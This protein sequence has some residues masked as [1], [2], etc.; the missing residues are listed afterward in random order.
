MTVPLIVL[1]VASLFTTSASAF[2]TDRYRELVGMTVVM[3]DGGT[4]DLDTLTQYQEELIAIGVR[5]AREYAAATPDDAALMNFVADSADA[6]KGMSL[7][8][9]EAAWH[10][11][12][13]L[14]EI[15]IDFH[16]LDHF[17][18]AVSHMDTV[19]HPA[20]AYIALREYRAHPNPD[21]LDQIRDELSEVLAHVS[22]L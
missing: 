11:G 10:E 6:M 7:D 12:E 1:A 18:K 16:S 15:G 3:I 4:I 14:N 9:I 13:A 2:E 21:F 20:T 19:V 8:G 22:H 17:G 5:G